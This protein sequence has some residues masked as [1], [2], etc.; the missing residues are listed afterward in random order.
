MS[1]NEDPKV[2][3]QSGKVNDK[4]PDPNDETK[5]RDAEAVLRKNQELLTNISKIKKENQEL[6]DKL[7]ASQQEKLQAEGKKDE[8]IDHYKKENDVLKGNLNSAVGGFVDRIVNEAFENKARNLG[9]E[10]EYVTI[11]YN[12]F[13]GSKEFR[14]P[15]LESVDKETFKVDKGSFDSYFVKAKEKY[16]KLFEKK[17]AHID[18]LTP[19]NDK[20]KPGR[21]KQKTEGDLLNDYFKQKGWR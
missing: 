14:D 19:S 10:K 4:T 11:L 2:D 18:D 15:V 7:N 13:S 8:L 3:D 17:K 1:V 12:E 20:P 21:P 5:V 16:P 6:L 9:V